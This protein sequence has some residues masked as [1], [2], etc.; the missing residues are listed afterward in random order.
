MPK[1]PN[2]RHFHFKYNES[3]INS[4]LKYAFKHTL[5]AFFH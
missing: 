4:I 2:F 5:K 1:A 3:I